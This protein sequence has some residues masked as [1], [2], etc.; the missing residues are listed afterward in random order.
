MMEA[1]WDVVAACP[2]IQ[3][4]L[5]VKSKQFKPLL[6]IPYTRTYILADPGYLSW[7]VEMVC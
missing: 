3:K 4:A 7:Y 1:Q 2:M 5:L 6:F